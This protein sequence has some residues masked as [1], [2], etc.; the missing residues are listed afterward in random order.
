MLS[1]SAPVQPAFS[2]GR[3]VRGDW[4]YGPTV[5]FAATVAGHR[6]HDGRG[7][8][9]KVEHSR[10]RWAIE[11]QIELATWSAST[12]DWTPR[13][14]SPDPARRHLTRTGRCATSRRLVDPRQVP[15]GRHRRQHR[16]RGHHQ[17]ATARW[18]HQ[19]RDDRAC[20][21]P[22]RHPHAG[23]AR[24]LAVCRSG[25]APGASAD[26]V[27]R[28]ADLLAAWDA[29]ARQGAAVAAAPATKYPNTATD[30]I[31]PQS[32]HWTSARWTAATR[33]PHFGSGPDIG[34]SQWPK[35]S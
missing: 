15:P 24:L 9:T 13:Q 25:L 20:K 14:R 19:K 23:G 11:G 21:R 4:S 34:Q 32:A 31:Q 26:I 16:H 2:T 28:P 17:V 18:S 3:R 1:L 35:D 5:A 7:D 6:V 30:G 8:R 27:L 29:Q 22:Q 12:R 33:L 10:T